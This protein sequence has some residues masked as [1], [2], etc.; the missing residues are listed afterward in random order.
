MT[1][2]EYSW[3]RADC[4]KGGEYLDDEPCVD[5][6][7]PKGKHKYDQRHCR[8][9]DVAG[10]W[11]DSMCVLDDVGEAHLRPESLL[12]AKRIAPMI[13]P[14]TAPGGPPSAPPIRAPVLAPTSA[15][16][17]GCRGWVS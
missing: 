9:P 5:A 12:L 16:A 15:P 3:H 13:P 4:R 1:F 17:A 7:S 14:S 10:Y 8:Y 11:I 2:T 6:P